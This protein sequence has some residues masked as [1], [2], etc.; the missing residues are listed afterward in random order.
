MRA[1]SARL[2]LTGRSELGLDLGRGLGA[3]GV[4]LPSKAEGVLGVFAV[5]EKRVLCALILVV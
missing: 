5:P 3:E 4:D 2:A 1:S